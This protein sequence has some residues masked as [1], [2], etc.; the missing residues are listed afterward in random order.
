KLRQMPV[1][2]DIWRRFGI[3]TARPERSGRRDK[4][5]F[6]NFGFPAVAGLL[7]TIVPNAAFQSIRIVP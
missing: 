4:A 5:Q 7:A 2:I 3:E 6:A 1:W